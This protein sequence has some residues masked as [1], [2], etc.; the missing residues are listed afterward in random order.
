MK[1]LAVHVWSGT[2][3]GQKDKRMKMPFS[4]VRAV[5]HGIIVPTVSIE[6]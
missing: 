3:N 2:F 6:E 5:E 4:Q 1:I